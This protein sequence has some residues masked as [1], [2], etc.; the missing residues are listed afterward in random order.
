VTL[1]PQKKRL[2]TFGGSPDLALSW[3]AEIRNRRIDLQVHS[4]AASL[5]SAISG[6]RL[7]H[8]EALKSAKI[9][10]DIQGSFRGPAVTASQK[11]EVTSKRI[12]QV[13]RNCNPNTRGLVPGTSP[14]HLDFLL[15]P[16]PLEPVCLVPH[17]EV[18]ICNNGTSPPPRRLILIGILKTSILRKGDIDLILHKLG[19]CPDVC[20]MR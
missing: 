4:P 1:T 20:I 5:K 16:T 13:N 2:A 7:G 6:Q 3:A 9:R 17:Q 11:A 12:T 14:Q 8:F 15:D 19:G 10:T 18:R